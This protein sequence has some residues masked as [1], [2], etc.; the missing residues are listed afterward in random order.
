MHVFFFRSGIPYCQL[1][2][3]RVGRTRPPRNDTS[4]AFP[5]FLKANFALRRQESLIPEANF[6]L[7]RQ[8]L[9]IPEAKPDPQQHR[10][11]V[12]PRNP[13]ILSLRGGHFQC[14]TRQSLS[15]PC[16][17]AQPETSQRR[18]LREGAPNSHEPEKIGC[19]FGASALYYVC[20]AGAGR[21]RNIRKRIRE[22]P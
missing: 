11:P 3:C 15:M 14:P 13:P 20:A 18:G 5:D 9:L 21:P 7:R 22:L 12:S 16:R 19:V 17:A 4:W 1:K 10:T 2:D 8:E 6:V